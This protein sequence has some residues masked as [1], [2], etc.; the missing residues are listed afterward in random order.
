[1]SYHQPGRTCRTLTLA[2]AIIG[3]LQAG[4]A[5][6]AD[7]AT[8]TLAIQNF[9]H[10]TLD[11]ALGEVNDL[12]YLSPLYDPLVGTAPTGDLTPARGLASSWKT[13]PDAKKWTFTLRRNVKWHDGKPFT[14]DDVVFSFNERYRGTNRSCTFCGIVEKQ[15]A[16]VRALDSHT[17]EFT[18]REPS[19]TFL[20]VL[21]LRDGDL[22]VVPRHNY[23]KKPDGSFEL[24][25]NPIGTGPFKFEG[26]QR[27][28]SISY[29]ASKDYWDRSR[30]PS[31]S[32]LVVLK[33]PE[34]S[35]RMA[36]IQAGEADMVAIEAGQARD[37]K[38]KGLRLMTSDGASITALWFSWSYNPKF[39]CHNQWFREAVA[40][41]IDREAIVNRLLPE[42]TATTVASSIWTPPALG[43][44]PA[45]KPYPYDPK[46]AQQLLK[47]NAYDGRP[48]ILWSAPLAASP[49]TPEIMQLIQG[50]LE[51]VGFKI[52]L[53]PIEWAQFAPMFRR[54]PQKLPTD[55]ACN[56]YV[57]VPYPR[58]L[59]M[60]NIANSWISLE[61]GGRHGGYWDSQ[62]I[63]AKFKELQQIT[64]LDKLKEELLKL[65]RKSYGEYSFYPIAARAATFVVGPRVKDWQ[66]GKYGNAWHLETVKVQ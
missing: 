47:E 4:V 56:I 37:A 63:D 66:P 46:R 59:V 2:F 51:S 10:D 32:R 23:V 18:L 49:E 30:V 36:M 3:L 38:Q 12:I 28:I 25:G 16:D 8:F 5:F 48:V 44:D 17:V 54:L 62:Y 21:N 11:P 26:F 19:I 22:V 29:V 42:G 53:R 64:N 35:T 52:D 7:P 61:A 40:L 45:L 55:V 24:K 9:Q 31:Y 6:G 57:N 43:F 13:S 50:Y 14:A 33:R 1:M 15:I 58:P 65:N 39:L 41:A 34:A 20:E 60:E 27:G